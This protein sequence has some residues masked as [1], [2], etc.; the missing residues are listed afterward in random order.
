M[1][2]TSSPILQMYHVTRLPN[3]LRLATAE[4]PHMASVSL[5]IWAAVG[6]RCEPESVNG[7]SHFLEHM[8]FK[9]TQRRTAAQITR[10]VEG[11]GGYINACT[12]EES[13]C[14]HARAHAGQVAKL[15]DVL[16]DMYL[17]PVIDRREITR[18][19]R[20][21]K[22]EIAMTLDQPSQH[23]LELSDET[24]WPAQ[25]LGRS[26]AGNERSLDRTRRRELAGFHARHY[27]SGSTV[28][29]AAGA[30]RHRDLT[31]LAK[32]LAKRIPPGKRSSWFPATNGQARPEIRL[33]TREMEQ[34][35][36]ALGIR[37]CS[38]HDPRR[39]AL[40]LANVI[41]GE[42]MS[43]RLFQSIREE[44]GLAYSIYST[45]NFY[46]DTG[47]L[48]IAAGLDTAHAQKALRLTLSELRRL[49]EK[50]PGT[51]EL[52]RA[53]DYLIGQL[54]LSLENTESQMNWVGEQ[55]LGFDRIIPPDEIKAHLNEIRPGDIRRVANDFFRPERLCLSLVSPLK[56][57][58]G[59]RKLLEI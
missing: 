48:T 46:H 59:L 15:M 30:I 23:V 57:D 56:N 36:L 12:S 32:L 38:R 42:N 39:F 33:F 2:S 1:S 53:R 22:E 49:R 41:L 40:R 11:I 37:T 29:V 13:T 19:R 20:V 54:E 45:P 58:R 51:A 25:P 10:E 21:I 50:P 43:S 44:H 4:L 6:S 14:Y 31:G 47:S 5:G 9:G 35:Q 27:V 17:N 16:A 24:L 55:L 52:R 28:V 7:I 34:T 26:I 18:E 3:G 8:L